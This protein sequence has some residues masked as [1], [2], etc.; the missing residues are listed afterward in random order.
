M[1]ILFK[2]SFEIW[3]MRKT[4]YC[5][6]MKGWIYPR[7]LH[8]SSSMM[9]F[10]RKRTCMKYNFYVFC[11]F[12]GSHKA[13]AKM[14]VF[15]VVKNC[16]CVIPDLSKDRTAFVFTANQ[17]RK[18][19]IYSISFYSVS[20]VELPGRCGLQYRAPCTQRHLLRPRQINSCTAPA[21]TDNASEESSICFRSFAQ[22]LQAKTTQAF[23]MNHSLFKNPLSPSGY[24]KRS[25]RIFK[26]AGK[27]GQKQDSGLYPSRP[28]VSA[29]VCKKREK[30]L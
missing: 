16:C 5:N 25:S 17:S 30:P 20:H 2:E 7:T 14:Q 24:T 22:E 3:S 18:G 9:T 26:C 1:E 10:W 27:N 13:V 28:T 11:E 6:C 19:Y 12:W 15:W 23:Y 4:Q 8:L 21:W 29:T